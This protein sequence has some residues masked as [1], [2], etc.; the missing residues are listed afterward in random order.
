LLLILLL[1]LLVFVAGAGT[2]GLPDAAGLAG[3]AGLTGADGLAGAAGLEGRGM[4]ILLS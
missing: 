1:G 4:R 2:A 3:A